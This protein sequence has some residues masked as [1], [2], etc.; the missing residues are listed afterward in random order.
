MLTRVQEKISV[1]QEQ[2]QVTLSN[3]QSNGSSSGEEVAKW[4]EKNKKLEDEVVHYQGM[5][6]ETETLLSTLQV[7]D[8]DRHI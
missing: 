2:H 5:L 7:S 6:K 8:I 3:V 4:E 1:L